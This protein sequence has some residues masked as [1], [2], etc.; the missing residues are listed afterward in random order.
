MKRLSVLGGLG[1]LVLTG[2]ASAPPAH[3]TTLQGVDFANTD[4]TQF[5]AGVGM[6]RSLVPLPDS[7]R[8]NVTVTARDGTESVYPVRLAPSPLQEDWDA[9][10]HDAGNE[11]TVVA[12]R[13]PPGELARLEAFR[14]AFLKQRSG[15]KGAPELRLSVG[16][17]ACH[18]GDLP[19]GAL[20]MTTYVRTVETGSFVELLAGLDLRRFADG[21]RLDEPIPA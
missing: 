8:L 1:L 15:A 6:P 14:A 20:P 9:L 2:C 18:T 19:E 11:R 4:L 10:R 13:I 21:A 5:A 12:Y 17:A 16:A 7:A 3:Q